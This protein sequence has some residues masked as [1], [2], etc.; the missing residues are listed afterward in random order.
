[1]VVVSGQAPLSELGSYQSELKSVTGGSGSYA[2]ELSHYDPVPAN[3]QQQLVAEFN[4]A[5]DED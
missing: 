3:I 5:A 4:P 1:M 2:M